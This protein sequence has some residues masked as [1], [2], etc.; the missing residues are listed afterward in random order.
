MNRGDAGT[1]H[2]GPAGTTPLIGDY[3]FLSGCTTGAAADLGVHVQWWA[4]PRERLADAVLRGAE[5]RV[6]RA[7]CAC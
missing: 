1:G 3:R 6:R 4:R 2:P 7:T 5:P